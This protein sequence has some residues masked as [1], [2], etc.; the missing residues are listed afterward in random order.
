MNHGL[1]DM[2]DSA[3]AIRRSSALR[4][5]AQGGRRPEKHK[6]PHVCFQEAVAAVPCRSSGAEADIQDF[7][8]ALAARRHDI[9]AVAGLLADQRAR[10]GG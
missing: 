2:R 4:A 6:A 8:G 3:Q 5:G 9:D 1:P 10:D 7:V